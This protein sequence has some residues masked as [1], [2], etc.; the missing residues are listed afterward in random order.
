MSL[1]ACWVLCWATS[2]CS[3]QS[4][5]SGPCVCTPEGC[6]FPWHLLTTSCHCFSDKRCSEDEGIFIEGEIK[7]S[8][9]KVPSSDY[10]RVRVSAHAELDA[11]AQQSEFVSKMN[12]SFSFHQHG[13]L[14]RN[15]KLAELSMCMWLDM[16]PLRW[17]QDQRFINV[18]IWEIRVELKIRFWFNLLISQVRSLAENLVMRVQC[19]ASH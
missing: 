12:H 8:R 11:V 17:N 10:R 7:G 3:G 9:G 15:G 14:H 6:C 2:C 1:V 4:H 19:H 18:G 16:G 13:G 5:C